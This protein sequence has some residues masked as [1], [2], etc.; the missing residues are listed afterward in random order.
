MQGKPQMLKAGFMRLF[1]CTT[2]ALCFAPVVRCAYIYVPNDL[3]NTEGNGANQYPFGIRFTNSSMRYQQVYDSAQ[4]SQGPTNGAVITGVAFRADG[5]TR[6]PFS[7][8]IPKLQVNFSTT[9]K[10]PDGLSTNFSE[11]V[12][13]DNAIVY[14][15]SPLQIGSTRTFLDIQIRLTNPFLYQPKAG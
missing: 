3:A 12:G 9:T 14:G 11:N 10:G 7:G 1:V 8:T 15:P 13:M 6:V 4:F 5:S 2:F